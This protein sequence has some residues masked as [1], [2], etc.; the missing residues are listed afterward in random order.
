MIPQEVK[1]VFGDGRIIWMATADAAGVPNVA[2]MLQY[3]WVDESTM[4]IS[5][6]FMK[7]SKANAQATGKVC[8][9]VLDEASGQSYKLKGTACYQTEGKMY[10]CA[11]AKLSKKNPGKKFKGVVV[12]Q[13]DSVYDLSRGENAGKQIA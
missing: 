9:A 7:A 11:Q 3:W 1:K 13:I 10:D 12:C 5:D 8:L 6:V 4:V 2:P